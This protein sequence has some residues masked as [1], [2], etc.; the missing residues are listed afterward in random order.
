[1]M[2][3]IRGTQDFLDMSLFDFITQAARKHLQNYHH[4]EISTPILEPT[5]L[6]KRSLGLHT[7]VVSKEMF[8]VLA[9]GDEQ[10]CLRPEAT[11][12]TMRC[13][14][15]HHGQLLTPWK[16]FSI[17]PMFRHERPQKGR[18]RQFHQIN[19]E[20]IDA[21]TIT[22]DALLVTMLDRFFQQTLSLDTFALT[23]NFLGCPE[24]RAQF[25][26]KLH[27]FLTSIGQ[28][29]CAN[30]TERKEKNIMRVFDCKNPMCQEQYRKAPHIAD[31]LCTQ[32]AQEWRQL[33]EQLEALS[34]SYTYLPTLVRGLD[35]YDKTVFEFVSGA[36]GAQNAFCSGGRYD[37]LADV[38]GSKTTY[39]SLG[40][41][42][43]IERLMLLLEP[44][45]DKLNMPQ[46]PALAVIIPLENPQHT[47]ALLLAD[48]LHAN[49]VATDVLL[50]GSLKSM[51]RKANKMGAQHVIL[52]GSEEQAAG[53]VVLKNMI[54]GQEERIAQR[55][56]I[57]HL[58]K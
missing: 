2:N 9:S 56:V 51:M 52:I 11:A 20:I 58:K 45:K 47:L 25:K 13:F 19:V 29:I 7:D 57:T 27:T 24:D 21:P 26:N 1:M 34:V 12:S 49:N 14:L 23:I 39:P 54:T 3:T 31:N 53:T 10:I 8:T 28:S 36:L 17:G 38:L 18:F 43:G 41:A 33:K 44:H 5:E 16:V 6:F 48:E 42:L 35:Y 22:N 37:H 40:A 55:D 30:C 46:P 4:T 15:E 50:D 32:C